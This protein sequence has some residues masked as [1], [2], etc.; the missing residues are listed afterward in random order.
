[1]GI[2]CTLICHPLTKMKEMKKSIYIAAL[3]LMC[4]FTAMSQ[5]M[6][7]YGQYI[8]NSSV[9]NP[10]QAGARG[11]NQAGILGRYQWVGIEGAPNTQTA[12]ANLSLPHDIG[13]ALGI[14]QDQ[15]GPVREFTLQTDVAYS[16]RISQDWY[17][18]GG[19]RLVANSMSINLADLDD[20]IGTSDPLLGMDHRSGLKFNMG[21]GLLAFTNKHFVGISMPRAIK[22]HNTDNYTASRHFFIYGGS[23]FDIT[24][25]IS[26]SPSGMF[27]KAAQAPMQLDINAIGSY[28]NMIDFGPMIRSNLARGVID[29]IGFVAGYH[30]NDNWYFGYMYEFPT[31]RISTAT[32]QSHEIS[33]R[34][35]W[36]S[37]SSGIFR[38]P[39]FFLNDRR[40]K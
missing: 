15:A 9:L 29:A 4:S 16:S 18:S 35:Q 26:L 11:D 2:H 7:M 12:F 33:L 1:M 21:A 22:V 31:N 38:T 36:K 32:K 28:E 13:F 25:E 30:L 24:R 37:A 17:L 34:Y 8:F 14:Y 19:L 23:S 40:G 27:R 10:A 3:V 39:G 6:P 5:Q 20:I